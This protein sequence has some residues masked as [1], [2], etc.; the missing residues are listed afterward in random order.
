MISTSELHLR[1]QLLMHWMNLV[2]HLHQMLINKQ[3]IQSISKIS[4]SKSKIMVLLE[5]IRLMLNLNLIMD[6]PM[7]KSLFS[8]TTKKH[9]KHHQLRVNNRL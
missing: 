8:I 9:L 4:S 5:L 6:R 1:L 7:L 3:D 2:L